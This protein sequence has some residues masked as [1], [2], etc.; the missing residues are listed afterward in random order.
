MIRLARALSPV[1]L[2]P[3]RKSSPGKFNRSDAAFTHQLPGYLADVAH[4]PVRARRIMDGPPPLSPSTGAAK[5]TPSDPSP[6]HHLPPGFLP[7][8]VGLPD[9]WR[10][11]RGESTRSCR[12]CGRIQSQFEPRRDRAR[13]SVILDQVTGRLG[14]SCRDLLPCDR[15]HA[16]KDSRSILALEFPPE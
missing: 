3:S 14:G 4:R 1:L 12:A 6:Q 13:E 7:L 2:S 11:P 16:G 15:K 9:H 8:P 10:S 5:T